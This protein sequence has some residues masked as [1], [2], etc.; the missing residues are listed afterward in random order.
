MKKL[1]IVLVCALMLGCATTGTMPV[2]NQTTAPVTTE[3]LLDL[4]EIA[5]AGFWGIFYLAP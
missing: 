5:W 2:E 3:T 4:A 1:L